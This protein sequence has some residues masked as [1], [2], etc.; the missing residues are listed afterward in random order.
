MPQSKEPPASIALPA[1]RLALDGACTRAPTTVEVAVETPVNIVYGTMPY[2]VMMASP[3]DLA[4]FVTGFS[5]TEG[6][7]AEASDIRAIEIRAEEG[8]MVVEVALKPERFRSHLALARRRTLTG[9]TSC[10]LCGIETMADLPFAEQRV[11]AQM[12]VRPEAIARAL[13]DLRQHQALHCLTRAVHAAAW[14]DTDGQIV[15]VR[16]DVGRHNALD[17]LIGARMRLGDSREGFVLVT[18]R[19]SFEMVE[20]TAIFGAAALVAISAPT[21]LAIDRAHCLGL[22]LVATARDGA[23]VVFAGQVAVGQKETAP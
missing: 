9:R 2:A 4:D 10:G 17:K 18:S 15:T 22:T 12:P 11:R 23:A 21:S 8:G 1:Q 16:E 3:V 14:C 5:L 7:I 20:K 13:G 19:A 6:V